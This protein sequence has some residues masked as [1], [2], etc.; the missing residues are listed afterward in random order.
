MGTPWRYY[1]STAVANTLGNVGGI[2]NSAT[3]IYVASSPPVGYPAQFPF[4][5]ELEGDTTGGGNPANA[6]LVSVQSGS[7]TSGSPWIV[8]RGY[9]GTT[10][11][12]HGQGVKVQHVISGNDL[13]TA[14]TH[15][16]SDS[17]TTPLPHGLPASA[18][19]AGGFNIL[20]E[21]TL[22]NSTSS[23]V[24]FNNIPGTNNNLLIV[25]QGRSDYASAMYVD[26]GCSINGDSSSSYGES[27]FY[28]SDTTGTISGAKTADQHAQTSWNWFT[29]IAG[30][31]SGSAV[32]PGGGFAIIPNYTST[33]F[34]K[35]YVGMSGWGEAT[36][37][38]EAIFNRFGWYVPSSQVA[39]TSL[40]FT[41]ANGHFITGSFFGLYGFGA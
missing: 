7:G 6:E 9:D 20:A 37:T 14:A 34:G 22:T 4:T 31:Q 32:D 39:I 12:I 41:A 16:A 30:S 36:T 8:T 10:A 5:L 27:N 23:S 33:A 40:T 26:C 1:S 25:I 17:T 28:A 35:Q 13:T 15:I 21:Q 38:K 19:A 3:S 2:S 18:W 29:T 24:T 11:V